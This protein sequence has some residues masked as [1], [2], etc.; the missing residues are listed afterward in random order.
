MI[1]RRHTFLGL[2]ASGAMASPALALTRTPRQ[3]TGPFYPEALPN[4]S[5]A[6]LVTIG[7]GP[8]ATGEVIEVTGR[9]L[10]LDGRPIPGAAVQL[11]QANAWGRYAHSGDTRNV[12]LD[13]QFQGFGAVTS[14]AEGRYRFRTIKP[15]EYPGRTRHLHFLIGGPG[16]EP[17]ATQMYFA[18][19]PGNARDGLLNSI[20]DPEARAGIT[21]AFAPSPT[22]TGAQTGQFDIVVGQT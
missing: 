13:P 1:S 15:G 10:G 14:D 3:T 9:V 5:D 17:V 6:D 21:V 20:R 12:P 8:P 16:F 22:E 2:A 18:G 11:W 4:E 19:D 7:A